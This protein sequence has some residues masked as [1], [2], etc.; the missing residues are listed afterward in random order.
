MS[1]KSET[2][3]EK[4]KD[5]VAHF[6]RVGKAGGQYIDGRR[7]EATLIL[8]LIKSTPY[9][10]EIDASRYRALRSADARSGEELDAYCDD[11]I[12]K[13]EPPKGGGQ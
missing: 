6:E 12:E 3:L 5:R 13:A 10:Y 1:D 9:A 11:L 8:D 4:V 2:I 7:H